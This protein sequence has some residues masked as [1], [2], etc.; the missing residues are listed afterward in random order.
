MEDDD[1]GEDAMP[2]PC[3]SCGNTFDLNDGNPCHKCHTVFCRDCARDV[4]D[5]GWRC[6]RCHRGG[7]DE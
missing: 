7:S 6:V 2:T 3:V 4:E 1:F 5:V